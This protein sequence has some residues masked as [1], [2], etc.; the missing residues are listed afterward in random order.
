[1][2]NES[3]HGLQR[4]A[5]MRTQ[6]G[7]AQA[8]RDDSNTRYLIGQGTALLVTREPT[9]SIALLDQEQVGVAAL[10]DSNLVL[11]GWFNGERC[12]LVDVP[13]EQSFALA[14]TYFEELRPLLPL[15]SA[16]EAELLS[17]ARA[18]LYWRSRARHCGVCGAPTAARSAGFVLVCTRCAS[19]FFPRT[20]PAIIVLVSDGPKALLG[21]Q[22]S[23]PAG[24]Y[25][26]L[27]GFV[28]PGESLE[29]AVAREVEEE[30]GIR[31]SEARYFASQAWPFPASLMVGFHAAASEG[32]IHLDG[33]LE[34][35]RWFELDELR[36][37]PQ[38]LLPPPFTIARRLIE[39]WFASRGA[40]DPGG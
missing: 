24:R 13:P 27:A 22:A 19:E 14:G 8:A 7:W 23:W 32:P 34:D 25:S 16:A 10:D 5:E 20:D 29:Q 26:T 9:T 3:S 21:R 33:E 12:V 11:L 2:T 1:M 4:R 31:I 37:S 18:L 17:L 39:A 35:A 30:S 36:S 28:E 15:I 6:S 38:L 40:G